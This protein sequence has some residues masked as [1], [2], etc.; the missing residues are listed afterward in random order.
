VEPPAPE[1][2][3]AKDIELTFDDELP[4]LDDFP[5]A[6]APPPKAAAKPPPEMPVEAE[7][8]PR[9]DA[10]VPPP[11]ILMTERPHPLPDKKVVVEPAEWLSTRNRY[12]LLGV[13]AAILLI[14]AG[15]WTVWLWNAPDTSQP[16]TME[17]GKVHQLAL[18]EKLEGR[19]VFNKP[20]GQRLFVVQG[21]L[22]NH[23]SRGTEISWVRLRG[24]AYTD[25]NQSETLGTSFAFIGNVL[26]DAQ[27]GSW[28]VD[29]IQAFYAYN[30]G[31]DNTNFQ[32]PPGTRVPFQLVFVN[33]KRPVGR[34]VAQVVSYHRNNLTV[35]VD[36][37]R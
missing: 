19:Y 16:Y 22:E 2:L 33:I 26:S 17:S 30:N 31:R 36:P 20:S 1:L 7:P 12:V 32:I 4:P 23:F 21:S 14:V 27:L 18:D 25:Q 28:D 37:G 9:L 24:S 11:P 35:Y 34:T 10:E 6:A 13:A 5:A 8:S 15:A 29:A 3:A